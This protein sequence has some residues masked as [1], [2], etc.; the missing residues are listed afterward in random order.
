MKIETDAKLKI[1]KR[2]VVELHGDFR[3]FYVQIQSFN[4]NLIPAQHIAIVWRNGFVVFA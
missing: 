1:I 3:K 2:D 4:S